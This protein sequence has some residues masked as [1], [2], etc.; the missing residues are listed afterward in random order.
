M[1][2]CFTSITIRILQK[3]SLDSFRVTFSFRSLLSFFC[4]VI[5]LSSF[6]FQC[7]FFIFFVAILA[8]S[9]F[10]LQY[11]YSFCPCQVCYLHHIHILLVF[12]VQTYN[13]HYF[14]V[15]VCITRASDLLTIFS[16]LFR[17]VESIST[18]KAYIE[19]NIL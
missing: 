2:L 13:I 14:P 17:P 3:S 16:N 11:I 7:L 12:R 4:N 6:S 8:S 1:S 15:F 10:N 5:Y 9:F 19:I 18:S